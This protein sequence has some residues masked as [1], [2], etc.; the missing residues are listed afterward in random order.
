MRA[1][2]LSTKKNFNAH[3]QVSKATKFSAYDHKNN[4]QILAQVLSDMLNMISSFLGFQQ[5]L[6][7]IQIVL[8]L[9]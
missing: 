6:N 5:A 4:F 8:G 7:F 2:E 3:N 1:C 9:W